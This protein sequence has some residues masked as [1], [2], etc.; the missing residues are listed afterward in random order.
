MMEI[1]LDCWRQCWLPCVRKTAL[2]KSQEPWEWRQEQSE[3][4]CKSIY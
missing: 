4:G 2:P 1:V 3:E